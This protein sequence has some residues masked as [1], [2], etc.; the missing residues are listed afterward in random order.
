MCFDF[1][2][3]RR[4]VTFY[5]IIFDFKNNDCDVFITLSSCRFIRFILAPRPSIF[6][7]KTSVSLPTDSLSKQHQGKQLRCWSHTGKQNY[8][9]NSSRLSIIYREELVHSIILPQDNFVA[10]D[11]Y[12]IVTDSNEN[13]QLLRSSQESRSESSD[14]YV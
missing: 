2:I 13:C 11:I 6:S 4:R 3:R 5:P 8:A 12:C 10:S 9:G 7:R 1:R 14:S